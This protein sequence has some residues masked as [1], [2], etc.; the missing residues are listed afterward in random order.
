M[1]LRLLLRLLMTFIHS[2]INFAGH[3]VPHLSLGKEE[4]P[5][6]SRNYFECINLKKTIGKKFLNQNTVIVLS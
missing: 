2:I 5:P 6:N 3:I 1:H 4:F